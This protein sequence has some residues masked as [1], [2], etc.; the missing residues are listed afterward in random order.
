MDILLDSPFPVFL[1]MGE[2]SAVLWVYSIEG[3]WGTSPSSHASFVVKYHEEWP[4]LVFNLMHASNLY[5]N[6]SLELDWSQN[7]NLL[8]ESEH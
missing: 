7:L 4:M 1:V 5:Y 2:L 6:T 8:S 3:E